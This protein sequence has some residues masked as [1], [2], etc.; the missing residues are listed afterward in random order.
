MRTGTTAHPGTTAHRIWWRRFRKWGGCRRTNGFIRTELT[1]ENTARIIV[2][3]APTGPTGGD[4][5]RQLGPELA[6]LPDTEI[7]WEVTRS[8]LTDALGASGPP[9]VVEIA[10]N[11]LEDLRRGADVVKGPAGCAARG[12]ERAP[13]RSRA[14]RRNCGWPWTTRCRMRSASTSM[15]SPGFLEASLDGRVATRLSTGDEER[16]VSVRLPEPRREDLANVEFRTPSG[17]QVALGRGGGPSPTPRVPARCSDA[18]SGA[19]PR[20]PR[21]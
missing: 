8:A 21:T 13:R 19:P 10:G 16:A 11:A 5:A 1:E 6:D 14:D 12:L 7:S 18:T 17:R 9:I 15:S 2:R 3:M 4:V 20:S